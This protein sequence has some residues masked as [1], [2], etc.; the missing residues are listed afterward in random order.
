M[1]THSILE[2]E[3][4]N[5]N[6]LSKKPLFSTTFKGDPIKYRMGTKEEAVLKNQVRLYGLKTITMKEIKDIKSKVRRILEDGMNADFNE[7]DKLIK[8][9]KDLFLVYQLSKNKSYKD[10]HLMKNLKVF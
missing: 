9:I 5:N 8:D 7:F 3:N 2:L 4:L 10:E 1:S 6:D